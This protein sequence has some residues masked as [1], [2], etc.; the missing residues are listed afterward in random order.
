LTTAAQGLGDVQAQTQDAVGLASNVATA[1]VASA[2]P[3]IRDFACAEE[4]GGYF[5]FQGRVDAPSAPGLLVRLSGLP[6]LEGQTV[7]VGEDGCFSTV[8]QLQPGEWGTACAQVT[9]WWG[10]VSDPA[11]CLVR[12]T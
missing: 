8:I 1:T 10:Q 6:S 2:A 12:P 5:L 9:D 7:T 11:Y 3:V 4:P